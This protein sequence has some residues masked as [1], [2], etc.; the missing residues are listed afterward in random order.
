MKHPV[1][2][3]FFNRP[4]TLQK[5]F[6]QVRLA[7]PPKL[8][9]VQ[10]GAREGNQ[11]DTE[12]IAAC[13][14]IVEHID[15]E[16]EVHT[17]YSDVN[18]GCGV[19][20]QSGISWVLSQ[21]ESTIILE[22][23]C[24]PDQTFFDYCDEMLERYK[25]DERICYISGLNHFEEWDFGG[26]SYGFTRGGAIWGWATWRRAW[27]RYD[28]SAGG[29]NDGYIESRIKPILNGDDTRIKQ[30]K[31]TNEMVNREEKLSHWDVQWGLVKYAQNQLVIVPKYNLISNIGVGGDSTHAAG[32]GTTHRKYYDY[33][34]MPVRALEFPLVHP[35]HMLCDAEYDQLIVACNKKMQNR[36]RVSTLKNKVKKLFG[37]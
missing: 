31:K 29:I 22:D 32:V 23:D 37:G 28:Y 5:V 26:S 10:D 35:T 11:Q 27:A 1:T 3:I 15:W 9:L 24:V 21:E 20:P 7:R 12:K 17:N 14:K 25:D 33:N 8:F 4:D 2:L 13:R 18:L 19:R 36:M 6:E 16:C 34:N 30:W